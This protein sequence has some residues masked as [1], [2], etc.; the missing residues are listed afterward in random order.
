M[1]T[2]LK[3]LFSSPRDH[4]DVTTTLVINSR[5]IPPEI[6]KISHSD[7]TVFVKDNKDNSRQKY[8]LLE[9]T[10]FDTCKTS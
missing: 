3:K 8:P 9:K 10:E 4:W 2:S 1:A 5:P 6:T 7:W